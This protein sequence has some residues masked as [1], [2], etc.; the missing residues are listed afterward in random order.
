ML[1]IGTIKLDGESYYVKAVA[2]G[3]DEYYRGVGE[4]PGRWMGSAA[5]PLG[6]AGEVDAADLHA[7]WSGVDPSTGK[8]L[9]RFAGRTVAGFDLCFRAPKSVSLMAG[10][11]SGDMARAVR[12]AHE[13]AVDAAF[14]FIE[15]SA[16]RSRTGKDGINQI[17]VQGLAAAG[18]RHRTSRAGDPHL[19]THVLVANACEGRDGKWRTLDGRWLFQYAKTAGYLYE[20]HLRGELTARLGVEWTPVKNGI[21]DVAGI[22]QAVLEHFSDRRK[23]IREHLDQTGFRSARA[24]QLATLETRPAKD[25][26]RDVATMR[27][28]WSAKAAEIGFDPLD[29]ED[30]V[31]R[32]T[33]R[34]VVDRDALVSRLLGASGLTQ[35]ASTFV[36]RDVL[37]AV[38]EQLPDGAPVAQIE[39]WTNTLLD[40]PEAVRLL[41]ADQPGLLATSVIRRTNGAIVAAAVDGTRWSTGELLDIEQHL[42]DRARARVGEGS[43][44]VGDEVLDAVMAR[45]PTM[46]A[47]QVD[48]V[49]RLTQSGNGV[50]V[51]SA[52]AG[53][54]KTFTLDAARE[55]WQRSGYRV[56]GAALAAVAAREL[57]SSAGIP[58]STLAMLR[59][60]LNAGRLRLDHQTVL[61]IDEAGMAGTRI[62]APVLD[63]AERAGAKVVLVGDPHQLPEID[64]GGVLRGLTERLAPIELLENRRQR[65]EWERQ[66]LLELRTGDVD[67]AF[68]TYQRHGRVVEAPTAADVRQALVADWWAYRLCG[69]TTAMMA[70]RNSDVDDLNARAR[71]YLVRRGDLHGPEIVLDQR[72][73][74][75]GDD[76]ICLRNDYR[77]GVCNGTRGRV[78]AVDPEQVTL[79]IA[80][81][82]RPITLPADYLAA[83][84]INHAYA[85]TIYKAQGATFDRGLL[86]GTD[87]LYRERGYVGMSRGRISNHLYLVGG[88]E[89]DDATGHGA[90]PTPEDPVVAVQQ[91]LAYT[92]PQ[93]L[94]IDQGQPVAPMSIEDLVAEKHRLGAVL[95]A[96]PPDRARDVVA[97]TQRRNALAAE[98]E[99]LADRY[100]ALADKRLRG[101]ATRAEQRAL[102]Q[103]IGERTAALG[104]VTTELW[105][106]EGDTERHHQFQLEHAPDR[107]RLA[108]IESELDRQIRARVDAHVLAPTGYLQRILGPV[109]EGDG[110]L[111]AWKRGA[112]ILESHHLGASADPRRPDRASV[113]GS[114]TEIAETRARLEVVAVQPPRREPVGV[115][116]GLEL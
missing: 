96:G 64:A 100:D 15:R 24:A 75:A 59:I 80:V 23:E 44:S 35:R 69:E 26:T 92:S 115:H 77:L 45:R 110:A 30:V 58:S 39:A 72:P 21:A 79:T 55:A 108:I 40:R 65:D 93:R 99:P 50:D 28:V 91:A 112:H 14:D 81:D 86:L 46:A 12:G 33:R 102:G 114:P 106:A 67:E 18:F 37:R 113:L 62:L 6:L 107:A 84:H 116:F 38:A 97:L 36:R 111:R 25:R 68:A 52:A 105:T 57:E 43:A 29:L 27:A 20:A 48:M 109:P 22:D 88:I 71:A 90:L 34:D 87:E 2:S 95:A 4:A 16:A 10:L 11:G 49:Q 98:I 17:E 3:V 63:A 9:G 8:P 56:R 103:Q 5:E 85:T 7:L 31:D 94:A 32:D 54:G 66:A 61:V 41:E 42:V 101:R 1:S 73:Y 83:G 74:Q 82:G 78:V 19:H 104:R 47:E 60:D 13:A 89:P 70:V 51:V 53:T 76:I